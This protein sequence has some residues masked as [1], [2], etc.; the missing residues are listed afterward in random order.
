MNILKWTATSIGEKGLDQTVKIVGNFGADLLFDWRYGTDTMR[1]VPRDTLGAQSA[2]LAHS[3]Q[4]KATKTRPFLRL[5]NQLQ[6]PRDC[7]F[8]DIGA[9]KGRVLLMAAQYGFRK[10]V[11]IEFSAPLCELARRN[12]EL[13]SRKVSLPSPI[14]VVEAD[15]T[16][17]VF[18]PADRVFF[19]FNPFDAFILGKVLQNLRRSIEQH[20]RPV[21]LIYNDPE[22][23]S[24]VRDAGLFTSDTAQYVGGTHFQV[25]AN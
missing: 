1:W 19:M 22:H 2:N 23:H 11:G 21:T 7:H 3:C 4:Y 12:V 13:F 8:V 16:T 10:V 15:A 17:H 14:E 6:L 25:Y 24:V 18:A 5:L 9:G 20:P